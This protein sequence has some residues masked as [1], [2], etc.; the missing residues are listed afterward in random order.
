MDNRSSLKKK[1]KWN[2]ALAIAFLALAIASSTLFLVFANYDNR[3]LYEPL[4]IVSGVILV[5]ASLFFLLAYLANRRDISFI[6]KTLAAPAKEGQFHVTSLLSMTLARS[7]PVTEI[8][9]SDGTLAYWNENL[10]AC[11]LLEGKS[12]QLEIRSSFVTSFKEI[13]G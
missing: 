10:G 4:G 3:S 7:L 6:E 8:K 13:Q 2:L 9:F 11:P 5:W 12:Y 1:A